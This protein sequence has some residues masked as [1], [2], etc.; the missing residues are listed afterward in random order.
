M[1]YLYYP[2]CSLK[3]T[4]IGYEESILQVFKTLHTPLEELDDWNCCGATAYM[5]VDE[6]KAYA[7]A[8]RNLALAEKQCPDDPV[9]D[10]VA[11]CAACFLVLYK[12][13]QYLAKK[14]GKDLQI[15]QALKDVGLPYKGKV[16]IRHPLDVLLNDIGLE[17]IKNHVKQPLKGLRV[18]SYYG[19]QMLRPYATFDNPDNPQSMDQL[20]EAMGGEVI[21]WPL[22]TRCCGASLTGTVEEVGL[23]LSYILLKEAE[24]RGADVIATACPLC[25]FNLECYQDRMSQLYHDKVNMPVVYFSQLMGMAFGSTQKDLGL[26]RL[27]VPLEPALAAK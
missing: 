23:R 1:S 12:T 25:Q 15:K 14:N 7:L 5:A 27:F 4:G 13:Q 3:S 18:A 9:V 16:R 11:P 26:Q 22:K 24:N 19:C 2:G 6:L 10:V 21:D 17:K 8:S 20:I